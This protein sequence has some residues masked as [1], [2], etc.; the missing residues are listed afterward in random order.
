VVDDFLLDF[1]LRAQA[2]ERRALAVVGGEGG[3]K[4]GGKELR[5]HPHG[6]ERSSWRASNCALN[7]AFPK[8]P[9]LLPPRTER[10]K[11]RGEGKKL[12]VY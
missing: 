2:S 6:L 1:A 9:N 12:V 3:G 11:G 8:K 10:K 4:E 7:S 5:A